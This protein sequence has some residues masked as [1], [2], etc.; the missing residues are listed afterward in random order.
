MNFAFDR[1][2]ELPFRNRRITVAGGGVSGR[3]A[4]RLA[5]VKGAAVRVVDTNPG[6][7][8]TPFAALGPAVTLERGPHSAAQF[9][10]ADLII[11]SPGVDARKLEPFLND[12]SRERLV[13]ESELASWFIEAPIVAITGTNGKTTTTKLIADMLQAAGKHVF[14]GGNIGTPLSE[15]VCSGTPMDAVALEISSFQLMTCRTLKPRV[16]ALLNLSPNHLDWHRSMDEYVAAKLSL[17]ARQE[18]GDLAILPAAQRAELEPRLKTRARV[19]WYEPQRRFDAPGLP[20]AHNIA[21]LEVAWQAVSFLGLSLPDAARA[22]ADFVPP[23]HRIERVDEING[24]LYVD[25]SKATTLEAVAAAVRSFNR[26][27]RL[28]M[29]GVYK[30]GDVRSLAPT[31]REHV[32]QI[33]LFGAAREVFESALQNDFDVFWEPDLPAAVQ[34][35]AAAARPGDAVLLSPGTASFDLYRSYAQRGDHFQQIV[36]EIAGKFGGARA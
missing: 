34:R 13:A 26:P 4:A 31:F 8:P 14:V 18:E 32:V 1:H 10:E 36:R 9:A 29:G 3:A 11:L 17:F 2:D 21:N 24:V 28:L 27:V 5:A 22:A 15:S 20:G 6:L 7:D 16:G 19:L 25:D 30:G 35:L 12:R 23:R 33:G